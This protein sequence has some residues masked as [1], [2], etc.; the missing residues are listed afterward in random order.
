MQ[1]IPQEI[2][3]TESHCEVI[4][5]LTAALKEIGWRVVNTYCAKRGSVYVRYESTCEAGYVCRVRVSDHE[6]VSESHLG[7]DV[8][9]FTMGGTDFDYAEIAAVIADPDG[10]TGEWE[11]V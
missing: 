7:A 4:K 2:E 5:N 3:I 11:G 10:G 1:S 9:L 6:E 8:T